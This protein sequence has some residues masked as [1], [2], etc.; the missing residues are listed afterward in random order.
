M[1]FSKE[2]VGNSYAAKAQWEDVGSRRNLVNN[3]NEGINV[4]ARRSG[5]LVAN[6]GLIPQD[7]YQEFD[8]V[9]VTRM[10]LD[11]GDTYLNDLLPKSKSITIGKLV[12]RFRQ[13]STTSGVKTSMSGQS[14]SLIDRTDVS[15]DGSLVPIHDA[16]F[17]RE[18]REWDALTSGGYD[19][20]IDDQRER[21]SNVREHLADTFLDGF[22]DADGSFLNVDGLEWQGFRNDSRVV[23]I[24]LSAAPIFDFTD[25]G[26]SAADIKLNW[27]TLLDIMRITN[28]C[29]LDLN[30][31]VSKQ[32]MSAWERRWSTRLS[33]KKSLRVTKGWHRLSPP[34]N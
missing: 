5:V 6:D 3:I 16:S 9:S 29:G 23:Q 10:R 20:L 2:I 27:I 8:N 17:G 32:I 22:T 31:Y 1:I 19:A 28:K 24:D 25:T 14:G 15:Y 26:Q 21:V 33:C 13:V 4:T 11:D 30:I 18:W 7:V 12:H 34:I